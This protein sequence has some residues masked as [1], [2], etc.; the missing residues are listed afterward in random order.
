M[1]TGGK[2]LWRP[3]RFLTVTVSANCL[4]WTRGS[5]AARRERLGRAGNGPAFGLVDWEKV[6]MNIVSNIAAN[7]ADIATNWLTSFEAALTAGNAETLGQHFAEDCHWRDLLAFT[8][9]IT[10]HQSKQMIVG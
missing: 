1:C 7:E 5:F 9:N 10:P 2:D 4:K 6:A 8:W 3:A